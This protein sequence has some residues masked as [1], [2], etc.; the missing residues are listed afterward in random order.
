MLEQVVGHLVNTAIQANG[1]GDFA[2]AAASSQQ[3]TQLAPNL[4][5]GWYQLGIARRGQKQTKSA[6][7]ALWKAA[8]LCANAADAQN[9][10]GLELLELAAYQQSQLCFERA[11]AL[12]PDYAIAHSNLGLL[13][14]RQK[15]FEAAESCFRKAADLAPEFAF[16]HLH[17]SGVLNTLNRYD[18]AEV[19]CRQALALA[20]ELAPAWSNLGSILRNAKRYTEAEV[21]CRRAI[22]LD[23]NL[24]TAWSNLGA[25]LLLLRQADEAETACR[26]AVKL[27]PTS[28]EAW[29][30]LATVLGGKKLHIESAEAWKQA[31][32]FDQTSPVLWRDFGHALMEAKNLEPSIEA[33][34]RAVQLDPETDYAI[35]FLLNTKMK[36]CDWRDF[37]THMALLQDQLEND[38]KASFT[39]GVLGLTDSLPLQYKANQIWAREEYPEKFDLGPIPKHPA[40]GKIRIGYYSADFHNHATT[41]LMAEVFE[42]HDKDH[43]EVYAF[44]FGPN[45]QDGMRHRVAAAVDEFIEVSELSDL[46]I[47]KLSREK[48][49]DIAIDLKG[50]TYDARTNIFAYRSAPIQVNYLGYPGT[51]A[52]PY[53]DYLIADPVVIPKNKQPYYSEKIVYLPDSYQPNDSRRAIADRKFT[54]AELGLPETGFVFCCFNQ[55][56]K[57]TPATFDR[58]MRILDKVA[59]SVLWLFKASPVAAENLRKEAAQRGI[60]P[61]RLI[62]AEVMPLAEHLARHQHANLFLDTF[63]YNAH[64]TTSDA[65]W[66]GLPVVTLAG[67]SFTSRVA[68]SLLTAV[69]LPELITTTEAEFEAKAI[70]LATHPEQLAHLRSKLA[71]QRLN[72]PLFDAQ[73]FTQKVESAYLAMY[74]RYQEDLMPDHIYVQP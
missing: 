41:Y 39:F 52:A 49:I 65:L 40:S 55:N 63:P 54:R 43:F 69:G 61:N 70:E 53:I 42:L 10:I 14:E 36:A 7:E 38:K 71:E 56:Y 15:K 32:T 48:K 23:A 16:A 17:L 24:A 19:A 50:Y 57:I 35:G 31:V 29:R 26:Q 62:F 18:E 3:A 6:I 72:S 66:A 51:M 2:I 45:L 73:R 58:W 59:G 30:N 44:S 25:T 1:R 13:F 74:E 22:E 33:F 21:A 12:Q 67:E 27:E 60:D 8:A 46:E 64:T 20:P 34:S 28:S 11:V 47:A 9:D 68:S 37:D 4:P 5:H